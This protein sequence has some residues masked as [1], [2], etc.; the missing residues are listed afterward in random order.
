MGNAES[1]D[2]SV[3]FIYFRE[4]QMASP[5]VRLPRS[6]AQAKWLEAEHYLEVDITI[7]A[8]AGKAARQRV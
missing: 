2:R 6:L 7:S 8:H 4:H 1:A 3:C 5:Q